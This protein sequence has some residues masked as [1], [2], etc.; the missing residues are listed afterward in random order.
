MAKK[1][2]E[3]W[4][5]NDWDESLDQTVS[6][7]KDPSAPVNAGEW[8]TT[9]EWD[10]SVPEKSKHKPRWIWAAAIG[11]VAAA[12]IMVFVLQNWNLFS[13]EKQ[14]EVVTV[15]ASSSGT[16]GPASDTPETTE[17]TVKPQPTATPE[18]SLSY[19]NTDQTA[20]TQPDETP[21][22]S[23]T[24]LQTEPPADPEK[25]ACPWY[26]EEMRYYYQQL[27]EKEKVCFRILYNGAE[28]FQET[29]DIE[30]LGCTKNEVK[31]VRYVLMNDCPELFQV[32]KSYVISSYD[33]INVSTVTLEYRMDQAQYEDRC[34]KIREIAEEIKS[35]VSKPKDEYDTELT[36]YRWLIARCEYQTGEDDSTAYSDSALIDGKARCAG[37]SKALALLLRTNGIQCIEVSSVPDENHQWNM[38]KIDGEWY[39]CDVTWDNDDEIFAEGQND[40]LCYLNVP[41]RLMSKHTQEQD[42][43]FRPECNSIA[44]NYAYREGIYI[45]SRDQVS[46]PVGRINAR[47]QTEWL[48]GR[49]SFL[50]MLDE[51]FSEADLKT[52][53]EQISLPES[54]GQ[55]LLYTRE[56]THCLY[57]QG[58]TNAKIHFIDVGQGDAILVQCGGESLL[59]DA[60]P[61]DAGA[62]VNRYLRET[63]GTDSLN[64]VIATH[65]HD[66]HIGGMPSALSGFSVEQIWSSQAIPMS[67]WTDSILPGMKNQKT[68]IERPAPLTTFMLGGAMVTFINTM[69]GDA[70]PN[71]LSLAVRIDF[72]YS[73]AIFTADIEADAEM[74]MLAKQVPLKA[75]LLKV[76]HHGGNTSSSEAFIKAVSPEYAVIS[77]GK[78]NKHGHPH[79]E[80]LRCL[81]KYK[82][83][84][85]RTDEYGTILFS[86]DK[87]N[88]W[89]VEVKKTR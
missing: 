18:E 66:D 36:I 34:R 79:D 43:F 76:A 84:V 12:V 75:S 61:A 2:K 42:G 69:C 45:S 59:I 54:A 68:R 31:R 77:V 67:W 9:D 47:L 7:R 24:F 50:I 57:I 88:K 35:S 22:A 16:I 85:Y 17:P 29:I 49:R 10:A 3:D 55:V 71:D 56:E 39:Q 81:E 83:S 70:S 6:S 72:G 38:V 82:V 21:E 73:S 53:I 33:D 19:S 48:S 58:G 26:G 51:G 25:I 4:Q 5:I 13:S 46:D 1:R 23:L 8:D 62:T 80:P 28:N 40:Y 27:S 87:D 65:E 74:D 44:A 52:V 64:Y 41:D 86:W 78:G 20:D 63:L 30:F 14:P 15:S 32:S 60:G 89:K 11:S 37:Y